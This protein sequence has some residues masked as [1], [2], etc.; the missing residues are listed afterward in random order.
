MS[1]KNHRAGDIYSSSHTTVTD[2][3]GKILAKIQNYRD[4]SKIAIGIIKPRA[5]SSSGEK[6]KIGYGDNRCI[7]LQVNGNAACQ[8]VYV[9]T[10]NNPQ[11]TK[12]H[13]ARSAR[14]IGMAI[15]FEIKAGKRKKRK[16][17]TKPT[18]NGH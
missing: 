15:C 18:S 9:Y 7:K 3:T 16:R 6:V 1:T 8:E 11:E 12:L 17:R 4:I 13:I 14:N 5:K 2:A 10:V